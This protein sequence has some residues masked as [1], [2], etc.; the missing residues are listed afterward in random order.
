[1]ITDDTLT[2]EQ[3]NELRDDPMSGQAIRSICNL[4]LLGFPSPEKRDARA[5]CVEILNARS[6]K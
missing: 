2:D 4:A 3:I 1:M 5:F 6:A